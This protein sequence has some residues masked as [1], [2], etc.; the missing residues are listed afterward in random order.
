MSTNCG[1]CQYGSFEKSPK[2]PLK[3]NTGNKDTFSEKLKCEKGREGITEE[4]CPKYKSK[5]DEG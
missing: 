5:A 3:G 2:D 1:T 4:N